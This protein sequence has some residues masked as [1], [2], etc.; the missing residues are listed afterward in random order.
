M[1]VFLALGNPGPRYELSRHNY[2][3]LAADFLEDRLTTVGKEKT[4]SYSLVRARHAGHELLICRPLTSMNRS[5]IAAANLLR[6]HAAEAERMVVLHDDLDIP[7]GTIRLKDGG[8]DGGHK[9]LISIVRELGRADFLRLR[10]GIGADTRPDD[11][12]AYVLGRFTDSE[13]QDVERVLPVAAEAAL[14]LLRGEPQHVMNWLNRK[15]GP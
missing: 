13:L 15:A 2:G 3:W 11:P 9:G 4:A 12:V 7:L 1:R 10:L 8:G 6:A 14:Q 5:G